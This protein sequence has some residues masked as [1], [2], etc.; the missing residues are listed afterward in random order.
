MEDRNT[1]G[2]QTPQNF[3][4]VAGAV[5]RIIGSTIS[6]DAACV[7][8][9]KSL[10][11]GATVV[12]LMHPPQNARCSKTTYPQIQADKG[13]PVLGCWPIA[14]SP[15]GV[16]VAVVEFSRHLTQALASLIVIDGERRMYVDYPAT[17][18]GPGDDLWRVD[19]GGN[20]HAERFE[21]IFLLKRGT[22]YLLA[23]DWKGAEGSALSLQI[24]EGTGQ[25]KEV[26]TD[27]WYR[28]PL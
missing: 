26:K 18:T 15:A 24:D 23:V 7:L 19:D 5:Y 27:A 21:V 1:T 17:F 13:R 10:F 11:S 28:S 4:H 22:T 6:A 9:E 20:I 3:T 16:H 2:R 8:A 14:E 12:R 25:F